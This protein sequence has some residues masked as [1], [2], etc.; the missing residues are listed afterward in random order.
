MAAYQISDGVRPPVL[1]FCENFNG[2]GGNAPI[3]IG[4]V[5]DQNNNMVGTFIC[6]V[7]SSFMIRYYQQVYMFYP[8]Q[9]YWVDDQGGTGTCT[10]ARA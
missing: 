3:Q 9:G 2:F 7:N 4:S 8:W 6:H 10:L 1:I 5:L